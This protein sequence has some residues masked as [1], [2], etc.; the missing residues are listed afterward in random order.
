AQSVSQRFQ[1]NELAWLALLIGKMLTI[2]GNPRS[3][4]RHFCL[5]CFRIEESGRRIKDLGQLRQKVIG[6]RGIGLSQFING[7]TVIQKRF[8]ELGLQTGRERGFCG[9]LAER[10][11][12]C[13]L[14]EVSPALPHPI[15]V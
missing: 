6:R 9:L 14:I 13:R 15:A 4:Q 10:A 3:Q 12:S 1:C 7:T 5:Q 11:D 8:V 2:E